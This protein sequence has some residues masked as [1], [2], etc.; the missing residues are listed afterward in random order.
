[1][2]IELS[3]EAMGKTENQPYLLSVINSQVEIECSSR[4]LA[5]FVSSSGGSPKDNQFH[6]KWRH[7]SLKLFVGMLIKRLWKTLLIRFLTLDWTIPLKL[8]WL[9]PLFILFFTTQ[10]Q[11]YSLRYCLKLFYAVEDKWPQ[12]CSTASLIF[13]YSTKYV[14]EVDTTKFG[15]R[16]SETG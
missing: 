2:S 9:R 7:V 16:R 8:E 6:S 1:M 13:N 5:L 4:Y 10:V 3:Y 14:Q 12:V 15:L 11:G